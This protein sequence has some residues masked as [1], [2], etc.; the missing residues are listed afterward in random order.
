MEQPEAFRRFVEARY[1][2]VAMLASQMTIRGGGGRKE[3][4]QEKEEKSEQEWSK[5]APGRA[6][7]NVAPVSVPVA[8]P[9]AM[10]VQVGGDWV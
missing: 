4:D 3:G 6:V 7:V 1:D 9:A 2:V 10:A 5:Q 8:Q